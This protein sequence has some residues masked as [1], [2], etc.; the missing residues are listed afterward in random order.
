MNALRSGLVWGGE[1]VDREIARAISQALDGNVENAKR[2][3]T[4]VRGRLRNLRTLR[5]RLEYQ[6]GSLAMTLLALVGFLVVAPPLLSNQDGSSF[7]PLLLAQV[8][9]CGGLGGFLSVAIGIRRVEIDPDAHWIVNGL[10]GALRIVI[11]VIGS[12]FV[13]CAIASELILGNLSLQASTAGIFAIS[14]AA[15]FSE[16]F[17]PNVLQQVTQGGTPQK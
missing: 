9:A 1:S 11:A 10:A 3:L 2:I 6:T 12:I 4:A 15:G 17:V 5:G 16:T 13:Y 7:S 14:I 8:A